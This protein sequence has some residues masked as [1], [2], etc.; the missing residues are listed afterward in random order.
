M[1]KT[2][3]ALEALALEIITTCIDAGYN[4]YSKGQI[5]PFINVFITQSKESG[6]VKFG[7]YPNEV[8]L[9]MFSKS[10]EIPIGKINSESL[11]VVLDMGIEAWEE[12][13]ITLVSEKEAH[14]LTR[15][16]SI[17][18]ELEVLDPYFAVFATETINELRKEAGNERTC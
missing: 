16:A 10:I 7:N 14:K 6:A 4:V 15:I 13:K 18:A 9:Q 12:S 17:K 8:K 11:E 1:E 3:K 2:I 5:H